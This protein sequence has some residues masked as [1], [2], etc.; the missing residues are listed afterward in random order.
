MKDAVFPGNKI[1]DAEAESVIEKIN[2]VQNPYN[3]SVSESI[4]S[5]TL[6]SDVDYAVELLKRCSWYYLFYEHPM[7]QYLNKLF[8]VERE[9]VASFFKNRINPKKMVGM[10]ITIASKDFSLVITCNHD[11]DIFLINH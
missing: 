1:V 4:K 6:I 11:G 2:N 5:W 3:I 8:L 10:D 7:H 9:D